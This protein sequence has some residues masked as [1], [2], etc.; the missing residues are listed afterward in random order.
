MAEQAGLLGK[1]NWKRYKSAMLWA[2]A[3]SQ[4]CRMLFADCFAGATYTTEELG[5]ED[6]DQYGGA[7][8]D[9]AAG[10]PFGDP[11]DVVEGSLGAPEE[12]TSSVADSASVSPAVSGEPAA[13]SDEPFISD[14]QRRLLFATAKDRGL[15]QAAIKAI[16]RELTGQESSKAITRDVFDGV[17]AAVERAGTPA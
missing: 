14:K 4:L 9:P 17:L 6:T 11:E 2:R 13:P 5:A 8:Y 10:T 16:L 3:V 7:P 12:P 15:D 1:Q